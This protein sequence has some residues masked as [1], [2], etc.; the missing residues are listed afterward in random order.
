[1]FLALSSNRISAEHTLHLTGEKLRIMK[2]LI[3]EVDV[4]V[5]INMREGVRVMLDR[6]KVWKFGQG[7]DNQIW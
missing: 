6:T 1:M 5:C 4:Y 3:T 2:I 7:Y